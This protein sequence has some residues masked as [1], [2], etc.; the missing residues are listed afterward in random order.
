MSE[1]QEKEKARVNSRVPGP[2]TSRDSDVDDG[3]GPGV[4]RGTAGDNQ[5]SRWKEKVSV[6]D[7]A[8]CS[9]TSG[10]VDGHPPGV[11]A[12]ADIP[13]RF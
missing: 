6:N 2:V 1:N 5:S 11:E 12:L 10:E 9:L 3:Y 4:R 13:T 7:H 8:P